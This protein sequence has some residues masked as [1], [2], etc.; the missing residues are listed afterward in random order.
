M[1]TQQSSEFVKVGELDEIKEEERKVVRANGHTVVLF[2]HEGEVHAVDNRCPHMGFPLDKGTVKDGILTCDWHHARFELSCG[3]TFDPW[4]DDVQTYPVEERDGEVWVNPNPE[5][6]ESPEEHW[7]DRLSTGLQENISLV[8]AKSVIGLFDEDVDYT[9]PLQIGT[10]FGSRYRESGWGSGLTIHSAM[11]NILDE[12]EPKDQKRALYTGLRWVADDCAGEPPKFNQRSFSTEEVPFD[13]LKSWFRE[14]VEVR[15][16]DGAERC[17][18][19]AVDN[20]PE[21]RVAE[22]L[23]TAATDHLYLD[24]GHT[25]DFINKA[26]EVLDHIGWVHADLVLPT[27]IPQI[28]NATRSEETSQWRQPVDIAGML[29]DTYDELPELVEE[30]EGKSWE[31]PDGFIET[32]L[33]DD[34]DEILSALRT[35]IRNGATAEQLASRVTYAAIRRIV[36]FS[37]ANEFNDWNTVHHTFSYLNAVHQATRRTSCTEIY[38]GVLDGAMSV[39]LDRFLNTPPV[40]IPDKNDTGRNPDEILDDLTEAFDSEGEVNTAADLTAEYIDSG[41]DI[42]ELKST[43]G[44]TLLRE[45][46]NFHTLQNVEASFR[47]HEL[48]DDPERKRNA[49]IATT[50]YMSAHFPTRREAEQT[51]TIASRLNRGEKIHEST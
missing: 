50:R 19:T 48:L 11:A 32:L 36:H 15:D 13:R 26:F 33:S 9:V 18:L 51:F 27:V 49:L 2:H 16:Q 31:E 41:H 24:T 3:D 28:T 22:I 34:P 30:G 17:L 6:E 39:Y 14:T 5:Q 1:A 29:F 35:A 46:A 4:A 25:F 10:E 47:Q 7:K 20:L 44:H 38:R 45:D 43:L 42:G 23:F 21:E 40:P 8:M 37:T 12:L